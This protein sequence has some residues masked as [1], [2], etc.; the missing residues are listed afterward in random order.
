[1]KISKRQI[2]D[3]LII[4]LNEDITYE[5]SEDLYN[6]IFKSISKSNKKI[7]MNVGN[8]AYIN[9]FALGTIIKILQDLDK[10]GYSFYL[11]N[12][13]QEVKTLLKVTGIIDKFKFFEDK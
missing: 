10:Q 7:V 6:F 13:S 5:N 3:Y 1:M 12:A 2:Q 11:M 9:S 4:D 8:V